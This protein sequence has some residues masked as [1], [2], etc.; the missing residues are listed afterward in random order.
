MSVAMDLAESTHHTAPLGQRMARA[1]E[2]DLEL[3]Y[4]AKFRKHLFPSRSSAEPPGPQE[5]V[6]RHAVEQLAVFAPR[7]QILDAPVAQMV[8][9]L[10]DVLR[11]SDAAIPEQVIEVPK[12][13]C[14]FRPLRAGSYRYA[15]G[16]AVGGGARARVG[17]PGTWQGRCW[18]YLVP[19]C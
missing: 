13:L 12:I 3:H 16:G 17:H 1:G 10:L 18:P 11:L 2:D 5:R 6:Q 9:R 19:G 7:E 8:D 14:P 15:D 4:T